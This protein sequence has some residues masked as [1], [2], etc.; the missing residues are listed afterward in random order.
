MTNETK[1]F[2]DDIREIREWLVRIDEKLRT[3]SDVKEQAIKAGDTANAALQLAKQNEKA[4]EELKA[5]K[6]SNISLGISGLS[7]VVLLLFS[8]LNYLK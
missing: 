6:K 7:L 2:R 5:D 4:I 1:E 8:I 3:M